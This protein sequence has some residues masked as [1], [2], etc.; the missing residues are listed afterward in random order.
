MR[1]KFSDY[2][3]FIPMKS[4]NKV[5]VYNS[6]SNAL[7]KIDYDIY[8]CLA[9]GNE[10]LEKLETDNSK[11]NVL[12]FLLKGNI[13]LNKEDDELE[14]L[15]IKFNLAKFGSKAL[16]LTIVTTLDCN[17]KCVYCYEGEHE[18]KYLDKSEEDSIIRFAEDRIERMGYKVLMVTWYGG[19]PLLNLG[20]VYSLS[21]EFRKLTKK[22]KIL[23]GATLVTNGTILNK[24]IA[25]KLK[26][27]RVKGMQI[28]IDGPQEIHD[29]RRPLKSGMGSY[30]MIMKNIEDAIGIIP[31]QIRIN[32]DK[33]NFSTTT[34]VIE[35]IE[36][37]GWLSRTKDIS[38][39]VGYTREWTPKCSNVLGDCFSMREFC[40]SEIEFQ[41]MLFAR[42]Y[43]HLNLYPF[44]TSYCVAMTPHGFVI[45]PGGW[46]HK[47][48]SDVGDKNSYIGNINQ[49]LEIN[50][51][52]LNWI[53]YDPFSRSQC[54]ECKLFPICCGGCPYVPIKQKHK[55]ESDQDYNCTSWKLLMEDK[56]DIF[57]TY[58]LPQ[59][60]DKNKKT[61]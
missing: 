31:I 20:C 55:L 36:K 9:K 53:S 57:L 16:S 42:G 15:K 51:K 33:K 40:Q 37:K 47:C 35:E 41:K 27:C 46:I 56:M 5:L 4:G 17:L 1:Y 3:Y 54:R 59:L 24:Q 39:Y 12:D 22:K 30:K 58:G 29:K 10:G 61:I 26:K 38:A 43:K 21:K 14:F 6:I 52:L 19:E 49:P 18:K 23:Y 50:G 2:N 32:V 28:T 34:D 13:I 45:E 8:N 44:P 60:Q 48:W 7:A 11:E 25:K